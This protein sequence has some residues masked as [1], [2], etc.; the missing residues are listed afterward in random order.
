MSRGPCPIRC[1]EL[2]IGRLAARLDARDLG[3]F[4]QLHARLDDLLV[5]RR[6]LLRRASLDGPELLN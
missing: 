4:A 6:V 3:D 1:S 5:A 2:A